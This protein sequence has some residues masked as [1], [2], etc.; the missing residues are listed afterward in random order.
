[1]DKMEMTTPSTASIDVARMEDE[2]RLLNTK[3][4]GDERMIELLKEQGGQLS[5]QMEQI[6]AASTAATQRLTRER[7]EA[8]RVA[9]E[10]SGLLNQAAELILSG[11]RKMTGEEVQI[12]SK[13]QVMPEEKPNL[14]KI[15]KMEPYPSSEP[16]NDDEMTNDLRDLLGRLPRNEFGR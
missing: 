7:N 16:E 11:M 3:S 10:V 12:Q 6:T 5:E 4:E 14:T 2:I 9:K 1:M 15:R 13:A 8:Q